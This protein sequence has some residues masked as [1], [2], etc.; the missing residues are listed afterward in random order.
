MAGSR[1]FFLE[2]KNVINRSLPGAV[3]HVWPDSGRDINDAR[4]YSSVVKNAV[5]VVG[6]I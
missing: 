1:N 6:S 4:L 2:F 3:R 5:P